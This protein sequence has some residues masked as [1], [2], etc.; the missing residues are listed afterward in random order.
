MRY[1]SDAANKSIGTEMSSTSKQTATIYVMFAR[2]DDIYARKD[3]ELFSS[4]GDYLFVF[5]VA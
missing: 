2:Q 1:G 3:N 5:F 4:R